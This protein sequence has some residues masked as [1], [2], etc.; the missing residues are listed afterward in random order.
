MQAVLMAKLINNINNY[1]FRMR[2]FW[3]G[4]EYVIVSDL[5]LPD[6]ADELYRKAPSGVHLVAMRK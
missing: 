6:M 3:R 4:I 5:F 1:A 2:F